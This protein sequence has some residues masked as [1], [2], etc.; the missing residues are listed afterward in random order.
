MRDLMKRLSILVALAA[1]THVVL[2]I[3][4]GLIAH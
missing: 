2:N 1:V 3:V 4:R